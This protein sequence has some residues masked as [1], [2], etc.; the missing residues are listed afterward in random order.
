MAVIPTAAHAALINDFLQ[1]LRVKTAEHGVGVVAARLGLHPD[2]LHN[3]YRLTKPAVPPLEVI[4]RAMEEYPD[5]VLDRGGW[6]LGPRV[7]VTPRFEE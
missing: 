5:I 3:Y 1:K 6:V 2:A 4:L 7:K